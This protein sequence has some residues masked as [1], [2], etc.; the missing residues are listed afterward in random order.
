MAG[1]STNVI[2]KFEISKENISQEEDDLHYINQRKKVT[3]HEK[4]YVGSN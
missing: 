4:C 2:K 1:Q 3:F